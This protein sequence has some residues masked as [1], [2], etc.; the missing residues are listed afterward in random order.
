MITRVVD[1][2]FVDNAFIA[3]SK[4]DHKVFDG[5]GSMSVT[6]PRR[7]SGSVGHFLPFQSRIIVSRTHLDGFHAGGRGLT[8]PW[9]A[10]ITGTVSP[11][12]IGALKGRLFAPDLGKF[13]WRGRSLRFSS[14][15]T[16]FDFCVCVC[17]SV[18]V[19]LYTVRVLFLCGFCWPS[20]IALQDW[21][22]Q[23][24]QNNSIG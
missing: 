10:P 20:W 22:Q 8:R 3:S 5:H 15:S 12:L 13:G 7:R 18:C 4:N 6:R 16:L 19:S 17:Q 9:L 24:C 21:Q 2:Q 23:V 14:S 11:K 1:V